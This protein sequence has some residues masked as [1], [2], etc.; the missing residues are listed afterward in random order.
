MRQRRHLQ[1]AD[2]PRRRAGD[3]TTPAENATQDAAQDPATV[4]KKEIKTALEL[5]EEHPNFSRFDLANA[6]HGYNP[7]LTFEELTEITRE[8]SPTVS[9][10]P[11]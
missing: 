2:A 4:Y 3:A 10:F 7:R 11:W 5:M 8:V 6:L 1:K 9:R